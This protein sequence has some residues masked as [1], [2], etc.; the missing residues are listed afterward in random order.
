MSDSRAPLK[1]QLTWT[2]TSTMTGSMMTGSMFGMP[3]ELIIQ[4]SYRRDSLVPSPLDVLSHPLISNFHFMK[5]IFHGETSIP[6]TA[7]P[8]TEET[9]E[10]FPKRTGVTGSIVAGSLSVA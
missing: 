6:T 5:L 4:I 2:Q 1:S 9:V 10:L 3:T 8:F 7:P